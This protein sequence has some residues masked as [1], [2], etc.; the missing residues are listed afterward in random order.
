[1]KCKKFSP[2]ILLA[3]GIVCGVAA[4]VTAVIAT[5]KACNDDEIK[6]IN[7]EMEVLEADIQEEEDKENKKEKKRSWWKSFWKL[8]KKFVRL[9]A[10]PVTLAILMVLCMLKSHG[11]LRGRYLETVAA[12]TMLD[13]SYRDYR[14][15]IRDIAGEEAEQRFFDGTDEIEIKEKDPETG[16]PIKKKVNK[17]KDG[18]VKR[19]SPYEFDFN[20]ATAPLCATGNRE[21]DYNVLV[22]RQRYFQEM[23]EAQGYVLLIDV[24]ND[25]GL[26][27]R[28]EESGRFLIDPKLG[29]KRGDTIGFGISNYYYSDDPIFEA[30]S[31]NA[32]HHLNF[33]AHMLDFMV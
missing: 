22:Q 2:E 19:Y 5:K 16:K 12:Y 33:N 30:Q 9:Y 29:W 8:V 32:S 26:P 18:M 24:I 3:G 6:K 14:Q 13:N 4:I 17:L 23:L 7:E 10:V 20:R 25:L 21:H 15:R 1:M 31:G 11:I 27:I 28:D